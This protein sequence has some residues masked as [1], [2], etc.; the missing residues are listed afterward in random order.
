VD[1]GLLAPLSPN[2]EIALR[3][4]ANGRFDVAARHAERL[5]KLA[6]VKRG[7]SGLRL[8]SVGV[9]RL[10]SLAGSEADE[11]NEALPAPTKR[12]RRYQVET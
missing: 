1:R 8:T 3:R 7:A 12:A 2:E 4:V 6:L 9:Q 11:V 10:H 5:I